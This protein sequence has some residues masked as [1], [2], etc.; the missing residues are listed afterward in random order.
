[1]RTSLIAA[2]A[3]IGCL[4]TAQDMSSKINFKAPAGSAKRVLE[5][6]SKVAGIPL[7]AAGPVADDVILLNLSDVTVS[8]TLA[9]I[10]AALNGEWRK[11]GTGLVFY[12]GSNFEAADR[13]T[14]NATRVAEFRASLGRILE[15]QQKFGAF[16]ESSAKKLVDLQKKM[17]EEIS[18]AASGGVIQLPGDFESAGRQTP[19]A[20][21]IVA[22]LTRMSDAQITAL[23]SVDRVV[24]GLNPTRMQMAMPNGANQILQQFLK[25]T[26]T[27]KDVVQRNAPPA[28]TDNRRIVINGFGGGDGSGDG[29]PNLGIGYALLIS[30]PSFG[31]GQG[32]S[33]NLLVADPNGK[34]IGSGQFFVPPNSGPFA[35]GNQTSPPTSN[36]KPIEFS[37]LTKELAKVLPQVF[38]GGTAGGGTVRVMS[39]AISSSGSG[40]SFTLGGGGGKT[41]EISAELRERLLN[42]EQYDPLSFGPGEGLSKIAAAKDIDLVAYLPDSAFTALHQAVTSSSTPSAFLSTAQRSGGLNVKEEAGWMIVSP[43][44]PSSAREQQV[45]RAALGKALRLLHSKGYL[46]LDDWAAYAAKQAKNPRSGEIDDGYLR[47]INSPAA[48]A[49]LGQFNFGGGWQ[50]LQFYASLSSAQRQTLAQ[51]GQVALRTLS[52]YQ[53]GLVTEHI[54]N[55][56]DG[57]TINSRQ[58]GRSTVVFAGMP[59]ALTERTLLLPNGV[60]RDGFLSFSLKTNEIAQANS[61]QAEES[62]FMTAESLAF[63]KVRTERP[64]LASFG[65]PVQYD[66]YRMAN[67]RTIG[68]LFQLTPEVALSRQLEDNTPGTQPFASYDR[69]PADFRQKV[70]K[71]YESLKQSWGTGFGGS[72]GNQVPPP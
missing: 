68:F 31:V 67:Q 6:L 21:A 29:D 24:F 59:S 69:L 13:R 30:N 8:E 72:G 46:G 32:T 47:L 37:D 1:M 60:P 38:G 18:R 34:T 36:D 44:T 4:A 66:Q 10:A 43:K 17:N 11:E 55:S 65:A 15:Q 5:E 63:E 40:S 64:E 9:K 42:P 53:I 2:L 56:F 57:P 51:N 70:E 49:G 58:Q 20:R 26:R 39:V 61:S 23:T 12:R 33:V 54:Y 41:P 52:Q 25:D 16:N 7:S 35:A 22:L 27:F 50:T 14:E 62:R 3:L 45:N 48:D 19:A 71:A 28:G